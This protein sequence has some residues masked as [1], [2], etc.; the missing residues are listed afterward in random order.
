MRQALLVI[1]PA[2]TVFLALWLY[3]RAENQKVDRASRRRIALL[4]S[5][6][7]LF[8]PWFAL[9]VFDGGRTAEVQMFRMAVYAACALGLGL[10]ALRT[11]PE[12]AIAPSI[13]I[14]LSGAVVTLLF[15]AYATQ[16]F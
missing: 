10:A 1:F 4:S 9:P 8:L 5:G 11:V 13:L 14:L 6:I 3:V 7:F 16:R 12:R 2:L 15:W